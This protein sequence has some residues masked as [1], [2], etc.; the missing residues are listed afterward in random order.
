MAWVLLAVAASTAGSATLQGKLV[1]AGYGP[2]ANGTL[3]LAL[4]Q[5]AVVPGSYAVAAQSVA[6]FTSTDGSVVGAPNPLL[7]P[8]GGPFA[9]SF[10]VPAGTY[11]AELAYIGTGSQ[12]TLVSPEVKWT[13]TAAGYLVVFA[14]AL[15]PANATA[16]AVYIGT[17]PGGETLQGT[18]ALG[19]EYVQSTPLVSGAGLPVSN[20]FTCSI[21]GND[22]LMPA[23]T[24]YTATLSDVNGNVLAGYPQNWYISGGTLDVSQILPLSSNPAVRF[25]QPILAQPASP[26]AQSLASALNMN[27]YNLQTSG[28]VG[29][30]FFSGFWS[31]I[32]PGSGNTLATW[33]PYSAITLRKLDMNAQTAGVGGTVGMTL[34]V[35]DGTNTCTFGGFLIAAAT[36][37]SAAGS[38]SCSFNAG[39]AL[40]FTVSGDDHT[41]R[42]GN[43]GWDLEVTAR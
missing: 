8:T 19:Q 40:T 3:A 20:T 33:T 21:A 1:L 13:L 28:N 14:P 18:A 9:G 41:T 30:G 27:G 29:P 34:T 5:A 4:S 25:P 38:G 17:T 2:V 11:Y 15:S 22:T 16:Y 24:Y 7:A 12:T 23:Y 42:P 39:I 36:A 35:T 43:T 6:C 10:T 32:L 26:V 31:G 37:T